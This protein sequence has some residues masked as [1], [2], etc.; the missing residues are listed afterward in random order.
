MGYFNQPLKIGAIPNSVESL[1]FGYEFDQPLEI[2][3]IPNSV[4]SLTFGYFFSQFLEVGVIPNSVKS[5]NFDEGFNQ[6]LINLPNTI[7]E[8]VI[9]EDFNSKIKFPLKL[10]TF[11]VMRIYNNKIDEGYTG[12]SLEDHRLLHLFENDR[13][14]HLF[15]ERC[16]I[17]KNIDERIEY[18]SFVAKIIF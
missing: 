11:N 5:L 2:G 18:L 4:E 17:N 9:Y 12:E 10:K 13:R 1:T 15:R 14:I 6:N 8:L 16:E 3:A 7:E